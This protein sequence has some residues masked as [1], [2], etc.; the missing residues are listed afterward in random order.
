MLTYCLHI[1]FLASCLSF[2]LLVSLS[3]IN[4]LQVVISYFSYWIMMLVSCCH[5]FPFF[6][7]LIHILAHF[8]RKILDLCTCT[9]DEKRNKLNLTGTHSSKWWCS[10]YCEFSPMLT[11][12]RQTIFSFIVVFRFYVLWAKG[13][14]CFTWN[15]KKIISCYIDISTPSNLY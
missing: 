1:R 2:S 4:I 14:L 8:M 11:G 5:F 3:F 12:R 13:N 6:S 10:L 15:N 7:S 9:R